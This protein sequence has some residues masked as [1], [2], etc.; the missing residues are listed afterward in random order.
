V[1]TS[2]ATKIF[3]RHCKNSMLVDEDQFLEKKGGGS[4]QLRQEE[5]GDKE[6]D[7]VH[8]KGKRRGEN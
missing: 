7:V 5:R 4:H 8:D 2:P 1:K 6:Q 3:G